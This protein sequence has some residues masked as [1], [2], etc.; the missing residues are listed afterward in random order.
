M[1][2]SVGST[3]KLAGLTNTSVIPA[4]SNPMIRIVSSILVGLVLRYLATLS[5]PDSAAIASLTA[6]S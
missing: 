1:C 4:F 6:F 2:G 5:R 3:G